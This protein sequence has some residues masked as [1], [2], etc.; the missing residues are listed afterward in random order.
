MPNFTFYHGIFL[1]YLAWQNLLNRWENSIAS[2]KNARSHDMQS[3]VLLSW[4]NRFP[5]LEGKIRA[6]LQY[7]SRGNLDIWS[8]RKDLGMMGLVMH[9]DVQDLV[10]RRLSMIFARRER[11]YCGNRINI[12]AFNSSRH[13]CEQ[14]VELAI[15]D[16]PVG[17]I[18]NMVPQG[19]E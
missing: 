18:S 3:R 9:E 17:G 4:I 12:W 10:D 6:G 8:T 7:L 5:E 11:G 14:F 13:R 15:R 2:K 1:I 19:P 16:V